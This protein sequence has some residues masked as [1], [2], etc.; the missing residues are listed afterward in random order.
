[1][2]TN[3]VPPN[4]YNQAWFS[5]FLSQLRQT[6]NFCVKTNEE[7]GRV[8]LRSPD[9]QS[10]AVTVDNSGTLTTTVMDGSER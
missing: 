1:M 10:W 2:I 3:P 7:A 4:E 5:L 9:G 6:L 8:I